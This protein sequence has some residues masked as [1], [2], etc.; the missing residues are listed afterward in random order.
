M[1]QGLGMFRAGGLGFRVGVRV[2]GLGFRAWDLGG[3]LRESFVVPSRELS[4]SPLQG[5]HTKALNRSSETPN[6]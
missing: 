2:W 3:P 4:E 6:P 5:S 1:V